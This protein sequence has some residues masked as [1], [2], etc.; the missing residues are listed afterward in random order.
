MEIPTY[1]LVEM[2]FESAKTDTFYTDCY[3][4]SWQEI[5]PF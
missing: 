2:Y 4:R 3:N 1:S 5:A